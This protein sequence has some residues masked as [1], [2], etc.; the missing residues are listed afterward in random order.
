M[1]VTFGVTTKPVNSTSRLMS[2]TITLDCKLKEKC[3][4]HNPVFIV[5]GLNKLTR[6]NYCSW[7]DGWYWIDDLVYITNDI[8]EAHCRLDPLAT[9]RDDISLVNGYCVYGD[10]SNWDSRID[11]IRFSTDHVILRERG[12]AEFFS[13][14]TQ[15]AGQNSS[16]ILEY[17]QTYSIQGQGPGFKRAAM[18]YQTFKD[19]L[20]YLNSSVI[21]DAIQRNPPSS[22]TNLAG[23]ASKDLASLITALGGSASWQD[24]IL[25]A[26][27]IP[28]KFSTLQNS[29][30]FPNF[31]TINTLVI[32]SIYINNIDALEIKQAYCTITEEQQL[33]WASMLPQI[34]QDLEFIRNPRWM[35]IQ[36]SSPSG[37]QVITNSI[38][39]EE[40]AWPIRCICD[41]DVI[42][43]NWVIQ[44]KCY[45]K[46]ATPKNGVLLAKFGGCCGFNITSFASNKGN[47]STWLAGAESKIMSAIATYGLSAAITTTDSVTTNDIVSDYNFTAG[48]TAAG[49]MSNIGDVSN[50]DHDKSRTETHSVTTGKKSTPSVNTPTAMREFSSQGTAVCDYKCF[51]IDAQSGNKPV[52]GLYFQFV[53][54]GPNSFINDPDSYEAYQDYC[55]VYG[56]PINKYLSVS[57]ITNHAYVQFS[58]AVIISAA[59]ATDDDKKY[60]NFFLNDGFYWDREVNP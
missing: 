19:A 46:D 4:R 56:Y 37:T 14:D 47:S 12:M 54:W 11:D 36:V 6:Y 2:S 40:E 59:G 7:E 52:L 9:F 49:N 45:A 48:R 5:K 31:H 23:T 32:G 29:Q 25:N 44:V 22:F 41:L 60:I 15:W 30:K 35:N 10:S 57:D 16:V 50:Y 34:V 20:T 21:D 42:T 43:G 27:L 51:N 39:R 3:S 28:I 18:S 24:C 8:Q 33:T 17:I 53:F 13:D 55:D 1:N 58:D 26:T 38:L